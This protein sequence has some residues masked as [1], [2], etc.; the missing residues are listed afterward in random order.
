MIKWFILSKLCLHFLP[1]VLPGGGFDR[2]MEN[3][4]KVNE[5]VRLR[6]GLCVMGI[7]GVW[8]TELWITKLYFIPVCC[9]CSSLMHKQDMILF[10]TFQLYINCSNWIPSLAIISL[11]TDFVWRF[12][13]MLRYNFTIESVL[14]FNY[15]CLYFV[16]S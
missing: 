5:K 8:A 2:N 11:I 10:L 6:K 4:E 14:W 13:L 15:T 7:G 3:L 16:N 9:S 1:P 12:S